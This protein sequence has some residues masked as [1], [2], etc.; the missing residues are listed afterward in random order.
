MSDNI[1]I[2][3]REDGSRVVSRNLQEIAAQAEKAEKSV[4]GLNSTLGGSQK[5]GTSLQWLRDNIQ[6]I[7]SFGSQ[8][9]QR[10][11]TNLSQYRSTLM[12]HFEMISQGA[13][14]T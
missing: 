10:F 11:G 7:D 2:K 8:M 14:A 9:V 12:K 4:R 5:S 1:D 13:K 6:Q 3:V